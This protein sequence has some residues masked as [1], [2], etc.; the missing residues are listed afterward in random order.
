MAQ[1]RSPILPATPPA[2]SQKRIVQYWLPL[3]ASWLLMSFEGPFANG[4]IARLSEPAHMLAAFG[5]VTSIS[6]AIESPVVPLLSTSTALANSRGNFI[7]LRRFTLALLS[8]TTLI[9]ALISWTPLFDVVAVRWM[10]TPESIVPAVRLGMRIMIFWSGA[11]AWRRFSQGILIRYGQTGFVGKGTLVRL[12]TMAC[13][14]IGTALLTDLSGIAVGSL[15][16]AC[17]VIAEAAYAHMVARP[18]IRE[19]FFSDAAAPNALT[20]LSYRDLIKFHTPLAASVFL[21]L[22]A[23]PIVSAALARSPNPEIALAAWPNVSNLLFIARAPAVAL[24]EVVIALA[25][26]NDS[27]MQLRNFS[28][29]VGV[30]SSLLLALISFTPLSTFYFQKL[31]GIDAQL[32]AVAV[33]G[34]KIAFTLP[35]VTAAIMLYRG[36][37]TARNHTIAISISMAANMTVLLLALVIGLAANQPGVFIGA[38]ALLLSFLAEFIT[39]YFTSQRYTQ[40]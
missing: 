39:L 12:L 25:D 1:P 15:A 36:F 27:Q 8:L 31:I 20:D 2:L 5:I 13:V 23:R 14:A 3:A 24:P 11:I 35:L 34:G 28:L 40:T 32:T 18:I 16:L 21:F 33:T 4:V 9:H 30:A 38:G 10:G 37:M 7:K 19:Q 17:G 6:L 26:E 22:F 29:R